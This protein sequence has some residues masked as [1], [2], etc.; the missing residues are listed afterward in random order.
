MKRLI[1]TLLTISLITII[2]APG[3]MAIEN[4]ETTSHEIT[5][6][7]QDDFILVEET[8]T[9]TSTTNET[10]ST[11]TLWIP[12]DAQNIAAL[13]DNKEPTSIEN[14]N[15]LYTFDITDSEVPMNQSLQITLSYNIPKTNTELQKTILQDTDSLSV[16]F[17]DTQLY[18]SNNLQTDTEFTVRLYKPT[19]TP[20]SWF[21]IIIILLL[22]ILLIV[23]T[24]YIF[25]KQKTT[26]KVKTS[27]G[28]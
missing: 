22:V 19:E 18:S 12:S 15:N 16:V 7:T 23:F 26:G 14:E 21:T 20:L 24:A 10:Y 17:D 8:I 1:F 25:K 5:I 9:W 2:F 6:T 11:V 4:V 3:T 28:A 27:K 13:F